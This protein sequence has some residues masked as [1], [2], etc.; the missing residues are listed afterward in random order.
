M[1]EVRLGIDLGNGAAYVNESGDV[2]RIPIGNERLLPSVVRVVNG[3]IEVG[4]SA[5]GQRGIDEDYVV[6]WVKRSMGDLSPV[7]EGRSENHTFG[8]PDHPHGTTYAKGRDHV[9][10]DSGN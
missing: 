7:G 2:A 3:E 5:M 9:R 8:Q 4:Q 6:R 1:S 10:S